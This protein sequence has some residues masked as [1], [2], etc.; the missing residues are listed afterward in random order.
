ME[1]TDVEKK[2]SFL[3]NF[4]YYL[5]IAGLAFVIIKYAI[6]L[7]GPFAI[8]AVIAYALRRPVLF[9]HQ[10]LKV[11]YRLC[12]LLLV[13]S[14]FILIGGLISFLG[15]E[16]ISG[17]EEV[18]YKIPSFY[19][20]RVE[21]MVSEIFNRVEGAAFNTDPALYRILLDLE[22]KA[23]SAID[24]LVSRFSMTAISTVS[25]FA[26]DIPGLFIKLVLLIISTFFISMDYDRLRNFCVNQ[27]NEKTQSMFFQVKEYVVGTLFVCI[28]SYALIMSITF[29]ELS[30]GLTI[31]GINHSVLIAACISI[32]DILPVLGTGG[33]MLP[34]AVTNA[35]LGN[36]TL[37]LS[38]LLVYV[39]ITIIRNILEPKIVGGQLGLHP[40]VT[41][42]SMFAGVQLLGVVGLFGFPIFLSLLVH[43]NEA[44]TIK[45]FK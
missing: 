11:K 10:K 43:L 35:V 5:L 38:L 14:F 6:P 18:V 21:P 13:A 4:A 24:D 39:I 30:I 36:Y 37:C 9:L 8:A 27:M 32:F 16:A 3:I 44:G 12:A 19:N 25:G 23:M 42:A 45:I 31:I 2:R 34:W 28:R 33:I 26:Y 15:L 22:V 17:I 7:L 20:T 41:L 40:V 29:V 1:K